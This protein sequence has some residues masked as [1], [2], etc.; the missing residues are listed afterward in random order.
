M[1]LFYWIARVAGSLLLVAI[2]VA[3][4][5][6][7]LANRQPIILDLWPVD[8]A[9][10]APTYLVSVGTLLTGLV[11]G[12]LL[13]WALGGP[14]RARAAAAERDA[15]RLTEEVEELRDKH[16]ATRKTATPRA[17]GST[18]LAAPPASPPVPAPF[19]DPAQETRRT[20]S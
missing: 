6:F 10:E 12:G 5:V 16:R 1:R 11:V 17:A 20:G 15:R 13:G 4:I 19:I 14:G 2:A 9:F 3:V 8:R 18:L 7:S